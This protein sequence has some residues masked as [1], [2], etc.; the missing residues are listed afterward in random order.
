MI[1]IK[2]YETITDKLNALGSWTFKEIVG[3]EYTMDTDFEDN[4]TAS[5]TLSFHV[6]VIETNQRFK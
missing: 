3:I 4:Y 2:N 6:S 1:V 5:L